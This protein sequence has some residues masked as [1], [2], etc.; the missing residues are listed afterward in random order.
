MNY[1]TFGKR[2]VCV[3]PLNISSEWKDD[4]ERHSMLLWTGVSRNANPMLSAQ[5]INAIEGR[6]VEAMMKLSDLAQTFHRMMVN[7]ESLKSL[8][9]VINEGWLQKRK[10]ADGITNPKIDEWHQAIMRCGVWG[11]KLCGAG[12]GGFLFVLAPVHVHR[13][14][15]EATGLREIRYQIEMEGSKVVYEN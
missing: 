14:I 4:F 3:R 5:R 1:I 10:M 6:N 9:A 8:A 13:D 15:L 11:A 7:G 12:G 2:N